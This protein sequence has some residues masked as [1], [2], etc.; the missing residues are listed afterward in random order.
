MYFYEIIFLTVEEIDF[1]AK[2][3]FSLNEECKIIFDKETKRRTTCKLK[4]SEHVWQY[5]CTN[6]IRQ[7]RTF[8]FKKISKQ[9]SNSLHYVKLN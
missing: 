3:N 8:K 9:I 1:W 5:T 6:E 2:N 7:V 4:I